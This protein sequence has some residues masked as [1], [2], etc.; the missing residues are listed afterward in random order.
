MENAGCAIYRRLGIY[1]FDLVALNKKTHQKR[2][3]AKMEAQRGI[4]NAAHLIENAGW[5]NFIDS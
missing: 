2:R 3:G 1:S 4:R 5:R